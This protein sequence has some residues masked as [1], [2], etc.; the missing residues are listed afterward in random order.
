MVV[1][2]P[3]VLEVMSLNNCIFICFIIW[4][5]AT[6]FPMVNLLSVTILVHNTVT[7]CNMQ[8]C[9]YKLFRIRKT[10]MQNVDLTIL[11]LAQ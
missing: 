3:H 6:Y 4:D 9:L 7:T 11:H 2:Y 8:C 10:R 1:P 5:K